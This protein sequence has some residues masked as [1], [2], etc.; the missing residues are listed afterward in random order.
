M[1]YFEEA[2]RGGQRSLRVHPLL[3]SLCKAWN[4]SA[5]SPDIC[6]ISDN[7]PRVM[8]DAFYVP[9]SELPPL[10][11]NNNHLDLG[12]DSH[13][14]ARPKDNLGGKQAIGVLESTSCHESIP[15][16][17]SVDPVNDAATSDLQ[18][19]ITILKAKCA[20]YEGILEALRIQV[21]C[22]SDHL[23]LL[24]PN[25]DGKQYTYRLQ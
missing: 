4:A 12:I 6:S 10:N 7:D 25:Y 8:E 23:K 18:K 20:T 2:S 1:N 13:S 22:I 5:T 21:L 16:L 19:E 11:G 14:A 24:N 17:P 3:L 9:A 15:D